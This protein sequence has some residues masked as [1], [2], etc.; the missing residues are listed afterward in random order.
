MFCVATSEWRQSRH[1]FFEPIEFEDQRPYTPQDCGT[2]LEVAATIDGA[3]VSLTAGD[4]TLPQCSLSVR[5][6]KP[7]LLV[8]RAGFF[9]GENPC[10]GHGKFPPGSEISSVRGYS[11]SGWAPVGAS[12]SRRVGVSRRT[13]SVACCAPR[14]A[15]LRTRPSAL[16]HESRA[17]ND[18]QR[19][20]IQGAFQ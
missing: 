14:P 3:F 18:R 9:G 7:G 20:E 17:H 13:A 5:F 19:E 15:S 2:K 10:A 12:E 1:P 8:L 11:S 4:K 6:R 16:V